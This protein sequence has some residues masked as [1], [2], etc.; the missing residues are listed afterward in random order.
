MQVASL[1]ILDCVLLLEC[2]LLQVESATVLYCPDAYCRGLAGAFRSSATR[3]GI[4]ITEVSEGEFSLEDAIGPQCSR[5]HEVIVMATWESFHFELYQRAKRTPEYQ[6]NRTIWLG[7]AATT[8][9]VGHRIPSYIGVRLGHDTGAQEF[10]A[11]K[12]F[13]TSNT[14]ARSLPGQI[15]LFRRPYLSLVH[16]AVW[17][18]LL[19]VHNLVLAGVSPYDGVAVRDALRDVSFQ[20][21]SGNITFTSDLD[22]LGGSYEYVTNLGSWDEALGEGELKTVGHYDAATQT[23]NK[24]SEMNND[25]LAFLV[26]DRKKPVCGDGLVASPEEA[27]DDGNVEGGDGCSGTCAV[28]PTHTCVSR[29]CGASNCAPVIVRKQFGSL[30]VA[31]VVGGAVLVLLLVSVLWICYIRGIKLD[32]DEQMLRLR[33]VE[34][35]ERLQITRKHGYILSTDKFVTWSRSRYVIIPK[36]L[37]DSAVRLMLLKDFDL[38]AFDAFCVLVTNT[39]H[40]TRNGDW[41]TT[42]DVGFTADIPFYIPSNIPPFSH[43]TPGT[44]VPVDAADTGTI[45][46]HWTVTSTNGNGGTAPSPPS[47]INFKKKWGSASFEERARSGMQG[48]TVSRR[49]GEVLS[50][51]S[52]E[53]LNSPQRQRRHPFRPPESSH[54]SLLRRW[55]M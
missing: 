2:V 42:S 54:L 35:R 23:R 41:G 36:V 47:F 27:C 38:D 34:L 5:R 28:E 30:E 15:D 24:V 8:T 6:W 29:N 18:L 48:Q 14:E 49:S 26:Q 39:E 53:V 46:V 51:R 55:R 37:M 43:E 32:P 40:D 33:T 45:N 4:A 25:Q 21:A 9:E 50:R 13:W 17:A 7:L 10:R 16:D 12:N 52:G 44:H 3:L 31:L 19:A 1:Y 20:G 22:L 11:F